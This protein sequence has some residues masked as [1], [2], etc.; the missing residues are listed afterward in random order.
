MHMQLSLS[1][2]C[3]YTHCHLLSPPHTQATTT[4]IVQDVVVMCPPS[5]PPY[6]LLA[7]YKHISRKLPC[8]C[9]V[10]IHSSATRL[11]TAEM[12]GFFSKLECAG[13]PQLKLTLVWKSGIIVFKPHPLLALVGVF[14]TLSHA[15]FWHWWVCSACSATP[16]SGVGGCGL[17]LWVSMLESLL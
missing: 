2:I 15:H 1:P 3:T 9:H 10:H 5:S 16:T 14:C 6:A 12:R 17:V 4:G 13:K 8:S 11:A 7:L